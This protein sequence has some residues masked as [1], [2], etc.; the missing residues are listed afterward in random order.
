MPGDSI[1]K[2]RP[3]ADAAYDTMVSLSYE[4]MG[5]V[6]EENYNVLLTTM[7]FANAPQS[8]DELMLALDRK[9]IPACQ[10]VLRTHRAHSVLSTIWKESDFVPPEVLVAFGSKSGSL[11]RRS[12]RTPWASS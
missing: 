10:E 6:I 3:L 1:P 5:Q 12:Q 2:N 11:T 4:T 9:T 8:A 7:V